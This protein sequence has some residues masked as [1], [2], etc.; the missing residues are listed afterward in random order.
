MVK[1]DEKEKD[2]A[3]APAPHAVDPTVPLHMQNLPSGVVAAPAADSHDGIEIADPLVL[4]PVDLP[5]V[6]KPSNGGEW[7]NKEQDA[8]AKVLNAYAYKNPTKWAARKNVEIARLV[9]IGSN[10]AAYY[11]YSGTSPEG[12]NVSFKNKLIE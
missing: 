2:E 6:I 12:E 1:K 8:Y 9:E 5:L 10:P 7:K 4:R 3:A 11:K